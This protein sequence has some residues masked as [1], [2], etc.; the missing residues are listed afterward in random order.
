MPVSA[1][2]VASLVSFSP[3]RQTSLKVSFISELALEVGF[4]KFVSVTFLEKQMVSIQNPSGWS[5]FS[6]LI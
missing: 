2:Y 3:I 6:E 1:G 5:L 4:G